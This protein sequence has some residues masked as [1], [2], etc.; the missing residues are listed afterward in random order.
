MGIQ[1]P[2]VLS[3]TKDLFLIA[4]TWNAGY[5]VSQ[6]SSL[7]GQEMDALIALTLV[8]NAQ[9]LNLAASAMSCTTLWQMAH[10]LPN[11]RLESKCGT[12]CPI[13]VS[14]LET[15]VSQSAHLSQMLLD[16]IL[17]A[18]QQL[19]MHITPMSSLYIHG[20]IQLFQVD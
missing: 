17:V 2:L 7:T 1:T 16:A 13:V 5:H 15:S 8:S 3:A 10:A 18:S 9:A 19:D 20:H 14:I 4:H 12:T 11:A 6:T